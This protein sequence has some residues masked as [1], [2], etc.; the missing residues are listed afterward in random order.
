MSDVTPESDE[1]R[2]YLT[3]VS[4]GQ[5]FGVPI[6]RMKE[7][8][9]YSGCTRVPLAPGP[10]AGLINLRGRA[11]PVVDL[12]VRFG[13][14][15]TRVTRR[16]CILIVDLVDRERPEMGIL[17]DSVSRVMDVDA[18]SLEAA[19]SFGSGVSSSYLTEMVKADGDF[20]PVIDIEQ[21]LDVE[22]C[23]PGSLAP[24]TEAVAQPPDVSSA[25]EAPADA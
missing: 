24:A 5:T 14:E 2:Q 16:S 18:E 6:M 25:E 8:V 7:I 19:P 21:V 23:D 17:A 10:V 22:A 1:R 15:R 3:F 12:A 20:I 13:F 9:P 11:I 4:A